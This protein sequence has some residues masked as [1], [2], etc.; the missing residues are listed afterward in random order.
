[1]VALI[2]IDAPLQRSV[3]A[4]MD[5]RRLAH[6]L[7]QPLPRSSRPAS[8]WQPASLTRGRRSRAALAAGNHRRERQATAHATQERTGSPARPSPCE[9]RRAAPPAKDR[10]PTPASR[11]G[12]TRERLVGGGAVS[13]ESPWGWWRRFGTSAIPVSSSTRAPNGPGSSRRK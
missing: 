3:D 13:G 7:H 11:S 8:R 2:G 1:M 4:Y 5:R 6:R 10:R 12:D 9:T